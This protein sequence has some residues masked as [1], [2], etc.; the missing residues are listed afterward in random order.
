[1]EG[2]RKKISE[3]MKRRFVGDV[4]FTD[5]ELDAIYTKVNALLRNYEYGYTSNILS[6]EDDLLFV[7][8]VNAT[9]GW[10]SDESRWLDTIARTLVGTENCSPKVY[11]Y[12]KEL[13]ARLGRRKI[14]LYLD[15]ST[16][17]YYAT[18]LAHA[19]APLKSTES[20]FELCWQIFCEDL[21]QNYTA[22]DDIFE[23]IVKEMAIRFSLN[24]SN[25][26]D[27]ELGS[28]VYSLRAGIKRLALDAPNIM[29][30][31]LRE[32]IST[33]NKVFN[34]E[35]LDGESYLSKL[36]KQWWVRKE[37]SLG[38]ITKKNVTE[39][40]VTDYQCIKPKYVMNEKAVYLN[41]PAIRL[42]DHFDYN[43]L[44]EVYRC[45]DC[46]FST[47]LF[48]KGSGLSMATKQYL[49]NVEDIVSEGDIDIRVVVSH[50]GTI[51]Y[52]SKRTLER[53]FVLFK[54]GREVFAQECLPGNYNMFT[55]DIDRLLQYPE[56]IKKSDSTK[57]VFNAVDGEAIQS[58]R[59]T[60]LFVS[61]KQN[62]DVWVYA[63]KINEAFFRFDG[64]DYQV[65]DGELKIA[66]KR[67]ID[68]VDYGVRY[69]GGNFKLTD[70]SCKEVGEIAY[71]S[72][73]ELLSVCEPQKITI[74]KYSNN[75]IICNVNIV[76]FNDIRIFFDKEYYYDAQSVGE[77]RFLTEKFDVK[78]TFDAKSG[79]IF[80]PLQNGEIVLKV[81][82]VKWRID[83]SNWNDGYLQKGI[84]YKELTNSSEIEFDMPSKLL[85]QACL[86]TNEYL[87]ASGI[88]HN[89]Y[90][91]GQTAYSIKDELSEISVFAK[92]DKN[93]LLPI[94]K[95][96]TVEKFI[97]APINIVMM[98]HVFWAAKDNYIG[99]KSDV[100][101]V[102]FSQCGN[103]IAVYNLVQ[104]NRRI[105]ISGIADGFYDV[106][107][108]LIKEGFLQKSRV[109]W[110]KQVC[111]GDENELRFDNKIMVIDKVMLDEQ[112]IP[113]PIKT[114]YLDNIK[115]LQEKDGCLL[116]SGNMY[117]IH[118]NGKKV[119]LNSMKNE[120]GTF[121]KTNPMRIE[122]RSNRTCWI[123]AGLEGG[124]INDFL[125]EL[126][127]DS[128][129]QISNIS[130]DARI[131]NY[132]VFETK[133]K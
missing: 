128:Y 85:Y 79:E 49:L 30:D 29:A 80:L 5:D 126:F 32:T 3:A 68:L 60:I 11:C 117:F 23:L 39:K 111:I 82:I 4:I 121:D 106:R 123:V 98:R 43:P 12:L 101:K 87:E 53:T 104:E 27:F 38:V 112:T 124:D 70:F 94:L 81:P 2:L 22:N 15:G 18:I 83:D 33:I 107:V 16:K 92:I 19:Y 90:K 54:D 120:Y 84:W 131:I 133:E 100:F 8:M 71:Y 24:N 51:I 67:E 96:H 14:V 40:V 114:V 88:N 105:D 28:Q 64:E 77:V 110:K 118:Y 99:D 91:L 125:G 63:D 130:T 62:R 1:M 13:I 46:I 132:Y 78:T 48:T 102:I 73:S 113:T 6:S 66:A 9:K 52:D 129:N 127:L 36:V 61:E 95:I 116:Y 17:K 72:I 122:L 34:S 86:S 93:Q 20:F 25:E 56:N 103:D 42:K 26:D 31:F 65:I 75:K 69:E 10:N 47:E 50:F 44:L 74:F 119:Y 7:A 108:E 35:S 37:K 55:F 115:Y 97:D 57:Y 45:N 21:D 59:R 89:K 109:L 76:K 41:I 58:K